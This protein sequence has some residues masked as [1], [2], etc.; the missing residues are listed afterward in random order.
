MDSVLDFIRASLTYLVEHISGRIR[1][2]I[3]T[4]IIIKLWTTVTQTRG[5]REFRKRQ[6]QNLECEEEKQQQKHLQE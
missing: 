3:A 4:F 2:F 5:I 6:Q 1:F